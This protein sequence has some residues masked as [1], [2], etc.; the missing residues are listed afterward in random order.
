VLIPRS[1]P[2][3]PTL[4]AVTASLTKLAADAARRVGRPTEAKP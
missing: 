4:E 3:E 1:G 2:A